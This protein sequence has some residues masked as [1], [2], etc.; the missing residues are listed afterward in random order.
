MSTAACSSVSVSL[1]SRGRG[2]GDGGLHRLLLKGGDG[3]HINAFQAA[4]RG[5][6][7][8]YYCS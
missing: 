5:T 7:A 2:H 3:L 4:H 1:T 6:E 8:L